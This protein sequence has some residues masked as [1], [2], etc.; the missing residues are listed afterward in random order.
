MAHI[1]ESGDQQN[2]ECDGED[3]QSYPSLY[4]THSARDGYIDPGIVPESE[5]VDDP[6]E[7][8][9]GI[10]EDQS[11]PPS[12]N[13]LSW[14]L[15]ELPTVEREC[16]VLLDSSAEERHE[17]AARTVLR[18]L[19]VGVRRILELNPQLPS[20]GGSTVAESQ[21]TNFL[22]KVGTLLN[23]AV[24]DSGM[25]WPPP[26]LYP[27]PAVTRDLLSL[28]RLSALGSLRRDLRPDAPLRAAL[29]LIDDRTTTLLA[30][31]SERSVSAA[32][33]ASV[34]PPE[35]KRS[36]VG[37]FL[38]GAAVLISILQGPGAAHDF[39]S[40]SLTLGGDIRDIAIHVGSGISEAWGRLAVEVSDQI[41]AHAPD[42]PLA[43]YLRVHL[44]MAQKGPRS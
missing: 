43:M 30:D 34:P 25:E 28:Y 21:A 3:L 31:W 8:N 11:D 14:I 29:Q 38:S 6:S 40:D 12:A 7:H 33:A 44:E 5:P 32:K 27:P 15:S 41:D 19:R 42:L 26:Y 39:Y 36:R 9:G 23:E 13:L 16:A 24:S 10:L 20:Y 17:V 18:A 1:D 4:G 2:P 37:L 35:S 22:H